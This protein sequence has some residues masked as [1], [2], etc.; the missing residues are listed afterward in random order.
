[1][2]FRQFFVCCLVASIATSFGVHASI[3]TPDNDL[4]L[5]AHSYLTKRQYTKYHKAI[6]KLQKHPLLPYLESRWIRR[7]FYK[8]P[9][10][11]LDA[12]LSKYKGQPVAKVLKRHW[13]KYLARKKKWQ[14][15]LDY[16]ESTKNLSLQ[17]HRVTALNSTNKHFDALLEGQDLWL[18]G[19]PLPKAC[20]SVFANWK[21][22]GYLSQDLIWQRF[23]KSL[24]N[25]E[26]RLARYLKKKLPNSLQK[27]AYTVQKFWRRPYRM[28]SDKKALALDVDV[29][30][31]ILNKAMKYVPEEWLNNQH[32]NVFNG[33]DVLQL[34]SIRHTAIHSVA[35]KGREHAFDWYELA[36]KENI[37][38][39]ELEEAFLLGAVK[40]QNWP[41][42]THFYKMVSPSL[43]DDA[44]WQYW[45]ARALESLGAPEEQSFK[46]YQ[47]ASNARDFYGFMACQH[48]G[49]SAQ[50]NH[51]PT[52]AP[53]SVLQKT[54][55]F[56]PVKRALAFFELEQIPQ[57]RR[58]WQYAVEQL[59]DDGKQA[60]ALLAGR[61]D[62]P[63]RA[64][65]TLAQMRD[66]HDLQL[67]FPLA[68]EDKFETAAKRT[69]IDKNWIYGVAR[70]ESAFMY[71]ARSPVGATGL[72]QLMPST[73]KRV[74]RGLRLH[75][76]KKK[77]LDPNYNIRLGS[78]YLK[79]LLKRY[80]GNR[81]LATAAYNAGPGNVKKWVKRFDGP[82]DVWIESIPFAE[83]KEY[84][85]KVLAYSTIYSYRLGR[86]QPILDQT[87]L[88]AWDKEG[89]IPLKISQASNR[90]N[91]KG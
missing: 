12:F 51:D 42:F 19:I 16:W 68:H 65:L 44:K 11:E 30:A 24:E 26:Y 14:L 5:K 48:L 31:M 66:W 4:Y 38:T 69:R 64:I 70:Q 91:N 53:A 62:W 80:D 88:S 21:R 60:L 8:T 74:S 84:V 83:T 3:T 56:E 25:K 87:T 22:Q 7:Q 89:G 13:I 67:R 82:L 45:K 32:N 72:M 59:D 1:M 71:D 27:K 43:Q 77:L 61:I 58:E 36:K 47:L 55:M 6:E 9:I 49:I 35:V 39:N 76:S 15:Y 23:L 81:V 10:Q 57:A 28:F 63:D 18:R 33:L 75:Y 79:T 34:S 86:L 54:R 17:C 50:M 40:S 20:D 90:Q 46:Y 29:R 2:G 52:Y 78:Q 85:Q 37:L 73:A 41:L